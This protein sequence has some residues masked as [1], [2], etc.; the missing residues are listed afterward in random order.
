MNLSDFLSRFEPPLRPPG[1]AAEKTFLRLCIHCGKC[2]EIC[3]HQSLELMGGIGPQ[4]RTPR[5]VPRRE[6]C[7]LCMK[8]PPVCPTGALDPTVTDLH[9]AGMGQAYILQDRCHNYTD[10]TICMTCYDRCSIRGSAMLLL[11]GLTPAV[12]TGCVGCGVCE[13]VCPVQ[14]VKVV[15]RGVK[16]VP[17]TAVPTREAAGA[18][19]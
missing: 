7:R 17:P 15:P 13:Y 16:W 18:A 14:A 1:A 4:R 8:C 5:V 12:T 11:Y 19:S 10:G 2:V 6:P 9:R 3:P